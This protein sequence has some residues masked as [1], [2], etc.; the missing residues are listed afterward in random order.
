MNKKIFTFLSFTWGLP[1]SL[2]GA[3]VALAL[4]SLLK[5]KPTPLGYGMCFEVGRNWGGLNLG[6]FSFVSKNSLQ[7]TKN[8]EYGH[9]LQNCVYGFLTP[10]I[11][12]IPSAIRYWYRVYRYKIG[13]PVR[14]PYDAIWFEH[15]ATEW[16]N[17]AINHRE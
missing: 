10:I 2:V 5:I 6:Y 11:V 4:T 16:G 14:T 13:D 3:G 7:R 1:L 8:H 17:R 15:Q 12:T 9:A